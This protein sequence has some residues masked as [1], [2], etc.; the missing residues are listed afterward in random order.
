MDKIKNVF[1]YQIGSTF[2]GNEIKDFLTQWEAKGKSMYGLRQYLNCIDDYTYMFCN[3][4]GTA[5]GETKKA[6]IRIGSK[7]KYK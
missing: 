5:A 7:K 4:G 3:I 2:T 1:S 6:F